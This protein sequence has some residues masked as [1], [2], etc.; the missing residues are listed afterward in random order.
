MSDQFS[1]EVDIPWRDH[2]RWTET[3]AAALRFDALRSLQADQFRARRGDRQARLSYRARRR[4][5]FTAWEMS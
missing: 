1:G 2:T 5:A 4:G 3:R